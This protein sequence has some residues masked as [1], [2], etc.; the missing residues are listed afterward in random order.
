MRLSLHTLQILA[1][2]DDKSAAN[3]AEI[4]TKPF[5]VASPSIVLYDAATNSFNVQRRTKTL[6]GIPAQGYSNGKRA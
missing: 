6:P 3:C 2:H 1:E 5:S 4:L